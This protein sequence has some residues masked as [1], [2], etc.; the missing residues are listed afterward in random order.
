MFYNC[1]Y[2][3]F[4][5][6]PQINPNRKLADFCQQGD[7]GLL[8]ARLGL[9]REGPDAGFRAPR[10]P[11]FLCFPRFHIAFPLPPFCLSCGPCLC[12]FWFSLVVYGFSFACPLFPLVFLPFPMFPL[13]FPFFTLCFLLVSSFFPFLIIFSGFRSKCL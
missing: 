5:R 12:S 9:P 6:I 4:A 3:S 13:S 10:V 8:A 7:G 1:F 11:W 2:N